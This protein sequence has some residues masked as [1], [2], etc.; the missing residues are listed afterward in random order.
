MRSFGPGRAGLAL[1]LVLAA[2]GK[3]TGTGPG[4]SAHPAPDFALADQNP[5]SS[6]AGEAVSPRDH[7][8][9][10]S[11]WYFGSAT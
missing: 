11:G 9:R 4:G 5:T 6:T 8:D 3:E 7:L 1:L 2:C 10:V